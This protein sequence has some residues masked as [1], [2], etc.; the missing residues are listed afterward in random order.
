MF[1]A[2]KFQHSSFFFLFC[3]VYFFVAWF[4]ASN[5]FFSH[6]VVTVT[7]ILSLRGKELSLQ[8]WMIHQ[9]FPLRQSN[10]EFLSAGKSNKYNFCLWHFFT[11]QNYS[12]RFNS[13]A[14]GFLFFFFI[15][16]A[17][18]F[19]HFWKGL[20]FLLCCCSLVLLFFCFAELFSS[21]L[22]FMLWTDLFFFLFGYCDV[23]FEPS[24]QRAFPA[25]M[26]NSWSFSVKTIK[27]WDSERWEK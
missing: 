4:Y 2:W 24:R 23:Y 26:N 3:S 12:E 22:D 27:L 8:P 6:S 19:E 16:D 9:P 1:L 11:N 25:A 20:Y 5:R 10:F 15:R 13:N 18:Y 14:G 17:D 21:L 7:I